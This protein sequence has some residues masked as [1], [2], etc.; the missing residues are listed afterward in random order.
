MELFYDSD[1]FP[2]AEKLKDERFQ[3]LQEL[4][5]TD[6]REAAADAAGFLFGY[7]HGREHLRQLGG[8][9]PSIRDRPE[10]KEEL[11]QL[12][13]I[14]GRLEQHGVEVPT[15]RTWVLR[16]DEEPP[17]DLEFPLFVRT[18]VSS[19]KRGGEQGKVR[20]LEQLQN[21]VELLRRAFGWDTP[22]LARQ[23]LNLAVAGN[24]MFGK[25]PQEIRVWAVDQ[26]PLAWSF[27]YLHAV[28]N[29][30]GF[31]P[32]ERELRLLADLAARIT[33]LFASRLIV[34]DFVR[35]RQGRWHFLEAGPGAVAG[36]AHEAVFKHVAA[37]LMGGESRL[38][39]DA[40]GGRL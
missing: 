23:W 21:E 31:P 32:T 24:W 15:P 14:L 2:H 29:P 40:V 39:E 25:A 26:V 6:L 38:L 37:R 13:R 3:W 33:G 11:I 19:W 9:Y 22:I 8:Q 34:A 20:N 35:D 10:E 36:T 4:G 12:D 7:W 27:H 17:T 1:D 5:A 18:P 30:A 28:P 16:I